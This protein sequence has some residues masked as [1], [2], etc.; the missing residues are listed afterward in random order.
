[1]DSCAEYSL[2][3]GARK[4]FLEVGGQR[5]VDRSVHGAHDVV[6]AV[7]LGAESELLQ[8]TVATAPVTAIATVAHRT[9]NR[10]RIGRAPSAEG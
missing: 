7:V 3:D 1:M 10:A 5:V 6:D 2:G 8:A 9:S 4:Q